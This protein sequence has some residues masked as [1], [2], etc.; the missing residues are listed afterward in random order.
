MN[1]PSG[2]IIPFYIVSFLLLAYQYY[3]IDPERRV[4]NLHFGLMVGAVGLIFAAVL[5]PNPSFS[6]I[7]FLLALLWLGLSVYLLRGV[8]NR[9]KH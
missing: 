5:L 9:P 7:F 2:L 3:Q 6:I 8:L 4:L 1:I